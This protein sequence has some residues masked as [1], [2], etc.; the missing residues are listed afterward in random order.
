MQGSARSHFPVV[1]N[2]V[3]SVIFFSFNLYVILF[4]NLHQI[5]KML[6]IKLFGP[7][8]YKTELLGIC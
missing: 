3:I 6:L 5:V 2:V 4:S 1:Y 7:T 8:C